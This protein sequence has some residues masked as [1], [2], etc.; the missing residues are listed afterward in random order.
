MVD[1]DVQRTATT[2][3]FSAVF[4]AP[5]NVVFEAF[6]NP[7]YLKQWW[8]PKAWPVKDCTVDF[9]PGG[10]WRYVLAGKDGEEIQVKA[11]YK[12]ITPEKIV[13]SDYFVDAEGDDTNELPGG[14]TTVTFTE[15]DGK[16]KLV[17]TVAYTSEADT[18]NAEARGM[19]GGVKDSWQ[20][21]SEIVSKKG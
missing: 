2:L 3:Q 20:Q 9:R 15:E 12:E 5:R 1:V 21:L 4:D 16:T 17:S 10:E 19:I 7:E 14:I 13:Y 11:I 6:K 18:E 8:G